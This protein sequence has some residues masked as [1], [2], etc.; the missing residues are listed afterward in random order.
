VSTSFK[1]AALL[2]GGLAVT[3]AVAAYGAMGLI[4]IAGTTAAGTTI[5]ALSGVAASNATLAWL[6]GGA[7]SAGGAG[8][9]GG[10]VVLGGIALA[11][12]A[13]LGMFLG[14][15]KGKQKLNDA[16][17]YSCEVDVLVEK[18]KTL[19]ME[20]SQVRRGCYLMS[21]SIKGLSGVLVIQTSKMRNVSTRLESRSALSKHIIDPIKAKIFKVSLLTDEEAQILCDSVNC[22]SLLKQ[23]LDKPL[24]N[25]EGAFMS[26]ILSFLEDQKSNVDLMIEEVKPNSV[27][28]PINQEEQLLEAS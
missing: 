10:M 14:T 5:G 15:N 6:G 19:M 18:I 7:L 17:D 8:M 9:T 12:V 26:D 11:P 25:E 3:G 28:N 20:L 22:A 4:S 1:E 2:G 21:E 13:V 16:N 23:M 24:M 27:T